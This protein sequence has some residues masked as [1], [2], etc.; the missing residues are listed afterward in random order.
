MRYD[1]DINARMENVGIENAGVHSMGWKCR[2][3]PYG[4]PNR[5]YIE[6]ALTYR[7][8]NAWGYRKAYMYKTGKCRRISLTAAFSAPP[9]EVW[10]IWNP[11]LMFLEPNSTSLICLSSF[12]TQ[13]HCDETAEAGIVRFFTE[14]YFIASQF[15]K[16]SLTIIFEQIH[17]NEIFA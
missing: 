4:T 14:K 16:L 2:S 9:L 6:D 7:M 17:L 5:D 13:V 10:G 12:M 1:T 3:K 11:I 8:E 15:C